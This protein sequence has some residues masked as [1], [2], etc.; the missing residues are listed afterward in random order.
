MQILVPYL[1]VYGSF[2]IFL[3][4]IFL[5]RRSVI[6]CITTSYNGFYFKFST[7][8]FTIVDYCNKKLLIIIEP[9]SSS[10]SE[11]HASNLAIF[12]AE[13]QLSTITFNR[14][15][16]AIK[17]GDKYETFESFHTYVEES[18]FQL[19][20]ILYNGKT[21]QGLD[22]ID[23]ETSIFYRIFERAKVC[24]SKTHDEQKY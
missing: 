20:I 23:L 1:K 14:R 15:L 19:K 12:F 4:R 2:T 3:I 13:L 11:W 22:V 24:I 8:V 5:L 7:S 6:P 9:L 17:N 18:V 10:A 16:I 21:K